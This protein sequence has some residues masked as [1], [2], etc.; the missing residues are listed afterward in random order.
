M[1]ASTVV[2]L[3]IRG[4]DYAPK[5]S[6]DI[7]SPA[8]GKVLHKSAGASVDDAAKAVDAAAEA[9]TSWRRTTPQERQDKMGSPRGL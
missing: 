2:P 8:T 4:Q 9:L 7:E 5:K 6:F 3:V 1:T